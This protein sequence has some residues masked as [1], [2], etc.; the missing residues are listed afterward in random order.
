ML[1]PLGVMLIVF[2]AMAVVTVL[3]IVLLFA[4][5]D[6]KKKKYIVYFMALLA[7]YIAWANAQSSPMPQYLGQALLGWGIGALG[8]AGLV[9]Q[10]C[11]KTDRQLLTAKILVA[12][13]VVAGIAELFFH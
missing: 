2:V 7:M 9:L 4:L 3:A 8:A 5:K 10:I 13:S 1:N 11:G 12:V 6:E